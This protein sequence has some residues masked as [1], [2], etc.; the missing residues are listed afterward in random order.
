[1]ED[2]IP[3]YTRAKDTAD[4]LR[5]ELPEELRQPKVAIICGSGLGG[6]QY[7]INEG[8]RFEKS[9]SEIQNWARST[10]KFSRHPS[11]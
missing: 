3:L 8:V 6:L 4:A 10:G 9:Y 1:M 2:Q 5:K 7:T 11:R